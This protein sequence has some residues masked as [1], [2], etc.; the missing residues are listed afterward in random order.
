MTTGFQVTFD[1]ADPEKLSAF[2]AQ[3]LG[4]VRESPPD[5]HKT[6]ES[7][8]REAGVPKEEWGAASAVVDPQ[9]ALPR[10]YFQRVAEQ[11][12]GK[13]RVHLDINCSLNLSGANGREIVDV[14][15]ARLVDLGATVVEPF[16]EGDEYWVVMQDPEGNEFCV[17]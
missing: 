4:Y 5:G 11:K 6:W 15:V 17:Q 2:W 3:A 1:A 16:E 8:L 13:N 14:E 12:A 9:G 7:F 10:I